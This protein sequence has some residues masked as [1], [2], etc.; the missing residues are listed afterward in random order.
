VNAIASGRLWERALRAET[1]LE[2]L[3]HGSPEYLAS[4]A[5]EARRFACWCARDAGA[6]SAGVLPHRVLHSAEKHAA[7]TLP[8]ALLKA[9]RKSAAGLA[10]SAVTIGLRLRKPLAA[11]ILAA[12][13]TADDDPFAAARGAAYFAA[14]A[15][16]LREGESAALVMRMRQAATLRFFIPNPFIGDRRACS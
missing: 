7:G 10:S 12:V 14:L 8:L 5:P 2:M 13:R 6:A 16:E 11:L 3:Q 15:T 4:I 1:L 9:E